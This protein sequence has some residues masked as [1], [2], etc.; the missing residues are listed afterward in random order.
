MIYSAARMKTLITHS[1]LDGLESGSTFPVTTDMLL[2]PSAR[3]YA[4]A[5]GIRLVYPERNQKPS[6][7]P[8]D[9]AIREAVLAELGEVDA[10]VIDAVRAGVAGAT[11]PT[12]TL[13]APGNSVST[14]PASARSASA[15]AVH[16]GNEILKRAETPRN[17]A[18]LS[19]MGENRT[20]ILGSLTSAIASHGCDIVDV[21]QTLVG[22]YFTVILI[23]EL[24][25]LSAGGK[26]F[27]DFRAPMLAEAKKLGLEA[28]LMHEDIL[29]AMHRV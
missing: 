24:D 21:S 10:A 2:T 19:A 4:S 14:S 23:V 1:E 3:D 26:T 7:S 18:V 27:A 11:S 13:S 25:N 22:G 15:N 8:M 9:R 17:R 16:I 20:G 6:E 5:H 29:R 12:G 28:M